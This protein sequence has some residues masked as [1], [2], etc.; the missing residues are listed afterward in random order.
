V[1]AD[2]RFNQ[3]AR[4]TE[5]A[6]ARQ[7]VSQLVEQ[8]LN[9]QIELPPLPNECRQRVTSGVE[10]EDRL[11][12]ALVKTSGALNKANDRLIRCSGLYRDVKAGLDQR[13]A[14]VVQSI[15]PD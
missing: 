8:A 7:R 1:T 10:V 4:D 15:Q 11:D 5:Q 2:E 6:K 13:K 12:V 9:T 3:A 14:A